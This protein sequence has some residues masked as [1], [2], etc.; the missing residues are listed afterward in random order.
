ML[1]W[2]LV[3]GLAPN[4]LGRGYSELVIPYT[5]C[6]P[7]LTAP[8]RNSS[9]CAPLAILLLCMAVRLH[10]SMKLPLHTLL[11]RS[12]T[13]YHH[14]PPTHPFPSTP[15]YFPK[16][17]LSRQALFADEVIQV[18]SEGLATTTSTYYLTATAKIPH[19]RPYTA[20]VT[21]YMV[22]TAR[23]HA[24]RPTYRPSNRAASPFC[25]QTRGTLRST[26]SFLAT[27]SSS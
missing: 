24:T 19:S 10:M 14:P 25:E 2:L 17:V 13:D 6:L 9:L 15:N 3:L 27:T 18:R 16:E 20:R 23:N 21:T 4:Y 1:L 7:Y 8:E 22:T 5:E 26:T 12:P 11:P